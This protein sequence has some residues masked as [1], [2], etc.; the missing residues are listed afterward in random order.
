MRNNVEKAMSQKDTKWAAPFPD[1]VHRDTGQRRIS[2]DGDKFQCTVTLK[3][4]PMFGYA[5]EID[6]QCSQI[7]LEN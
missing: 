3:T 2:S 7:K 1:V 5:E 4:V 6:Q